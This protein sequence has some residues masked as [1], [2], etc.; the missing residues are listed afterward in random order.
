MLQ[1][2]LVVILIFGVIASGAF[3]EDNVNDQKIVQVSDVWVRAVLPVQ[4]STALYM[5]VSNNGQDT[6]KLTEVNSNIAV[7]SMIHHTIHQ[8]GIAKMRHQEVVSI[9]PG[10]SVEFKPGGLHVMLMGLNE[11]IEN[12]D[13]VDVTLVFEDGRQISTQAKV[14]PS[15]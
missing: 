3:A 15:H 4:K 2:K 6:L 9:A 10:E 12:G 11:T 14:K 1:F 8:N 13:M 7:H 5:T